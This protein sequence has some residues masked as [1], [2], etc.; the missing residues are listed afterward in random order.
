[1]MSKQIPSNSFQDIIGH[2]TEK[3][4]LNIYF[5]QNSLIIGLSSKDDSTKDFI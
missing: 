1:M 3:I 5:I 4:K 2:M